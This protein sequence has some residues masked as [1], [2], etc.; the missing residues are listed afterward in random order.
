MGITG[1]LHTQE[2]MLHRAEYH[3]Y[4][5]HDSCQ[6]CLAAQQMGRA[7]SGVVGREQTWHAAH[8]LCMEEVC[9]TWHAAHTLC[10][11]YRYSTALLGS[12]A[13]DEEGELT[14]APDGKRRLCREPGDVSYSKLLRTRTAPDAASA[15]RTALPRLSKP[16]RTNRVGPK[17]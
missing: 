14:N 10:M 16:H 2:S 11:G 3:A 7:P 13:D 4:M 8:P 9:R 12:P 17:D 1:W 5:G 15:R 6:V